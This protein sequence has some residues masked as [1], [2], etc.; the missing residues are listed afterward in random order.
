M[1]DPLSSTEGTDETNAKN[2]FIGRIEFSRVECDCEDCQKG[3]EMAQSDWDGYDIEHFLHV[4]ALSEYDGPFNV[5]GMNVKGDLKTKFMLFLGHVE[6]IH[7]G[8]PMRQIVSEAQDIE[9]GDVTVED[10]LDY[11]VDR[12]YEFR[13]I[14]FSED[15][16]FT[17][18]A[19]GQSFHLKKDMMVGDDPN[20]LLVPV[21][22]VTDDNELADLGVEETPD[23]EDI[24]VIDEV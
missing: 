14:T 8:T 7:D 4:E 24:E 22:E 19:A 2:N 16:E 21:R 1:S 15:E 20:P 3:D 6:N 12:V 9:A 23:D 17:Y 5:F 13:E 18:E 11:F 10:I